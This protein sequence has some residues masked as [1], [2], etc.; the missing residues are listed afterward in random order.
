MRKLISFFFLLAFAGT[1]LAQTGAR[2]EPTGPFAGIVSV[3]SGPIPYL[4]A[5]P[6]V[7]LNWCSYPANSVQ[8]SPCT[9]Y[10]PTF[11]DLTLATPCSST[12]PIVLQ[13]SNIC[14]STGDNFGNL[15]VYYDASVASHTYTI[16]SGSVTY[17]P[18]L[19]SPG[20]T[21][22]GAGACS[23]GTCLGIP[24]LGSP[25][26]V[27]FDGADSITAI[28]GPSDMNRAYGYVAAN[29]ANVVH[30]AG[31]ETVNGSK[32]FGNDMTINAN[33]NLNGTL[34]F[35]Q[36]G[37]LLISGI[38]QTSTP[39]VPAGK[40]YSLYLK[41]GIFNCILANTNP[42][43]GFAPSGI[44]YVNPLGQSWSQTFTSGM[45]LTG[46][47]TGV[48]CAT[49]T[50]TLTSCP[51]GGDTKTGLYQV[52]IADGVNG[53]EAVTITGGTCALA[54]GTSGTMTFV[55]FFSHT[56]Y[57]FG[58]A[59]SGIQEAINTACGISIVLPYYNSQ[60]NV[61][62]PAN[63]PYL[64]G[65]NPGS[66][67][68]LNNYNVYGTIVFHANQSILSGYGVSINCRETL[69]GPCLQIGDRVLSGNYQ[70]N[71]VS[72][73]TFR[74]AVDVSGIAAYAGV[75]VATTA[76]AGSVITETTA[77]A[78]SFRPKDMVVTLFTDDP[79]YWGDEI[80]ST[81][82]SSTTFTTGLGGMQPAGPSQNTPGV[83]AL[84]YCAILDNGNDT[85][86]YDIHYDYTGNA[87]AFNNFF[88]FWDDE[89]AIVDNFNSGG[90]GL[91]RNINWAGAYI[92]SAGAHVSQI[93][94][95]VITVK[96]SDITAGGSNGVTVYNSNSVNIEDTILQ[97][98]ALWQ[99]H[100]SNDLGGFQGVYLQNIYPESGAQVNPLSPAK[101]PFPGLGVGGLIVGSS[102]GA[103]NPRIAGNTGV[104]GSFPSGAISF[105]L[106]SVTSGGVYS[107]V[108]SNTFAANIG[109]GGTVSFSGWSNSANNI[110][111]AVV[112]SFTSSTISVSN[113]AIAACPTLAVTV[114]ENKAA[115]ATGSTPFTY[116][117]VANDTTLGSQTSPMQILNWTSTLGDSI[118]VRWP[119]VANLADTITY[120]VIRMTTPFSTD[121]TKPYPYNSG[122]GTTGCPGGAAGICGYVALGI[123]QATACNVAG[124]PTLV[125]TYTDT[126]SSTTSPY[127]VKQGNYTAAGSGSA[128]GH[129]TFWPGSLVSVNKTVTVDTEAGPVV[130]VGLN[131]NP[132]QAANQC[133]SLGVASPGGYSACTSS[134]MQ[135]N[136][137]PN[138]SATLMGDGS[139]ASGMSMSKG[140]LN[141]PNSASAP[142]DPHHVITI[143]DSQPALTFATPTFRPLASV[144]DCFIGL[145]V[146][147]NTSPSLG[148][149]SFGCPV[150][151]TRYIGQVGNGVTQNWL[152]RLTATKDQ[153]KV[154]IQI[155]VAAFSTLAACAAGTEGMQA[156]ISD[157]TTNTWGA[158]ITG[159]GANHVL[160][161]CNGTNW[162]VS[163]K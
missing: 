17:G 22:G 81:V 131:G 19:Y 106:A 136:S 120:D 163:A 158:T 83:V 152:E 88:D 42:C 132:I 123:T 13:G 21:G 26:L 156:S 162:T 7:K 35:T 154:P 148:Q 71:T 78:H 8:G 80:I 3:S 43:S 58:T 139:V 68:S 20:G 63:G 64:S 92:F 82:P 126:G 133:S 79:A 128:F 113:P 127:T 11:T 134:H 36:A 2:W 12:Q 59:S 118:P 95:P 84:E 32:T 91:N 121:I 96:N 24:P 49:Q 151:L 16:T 99:V 62:I 161:Y 29:D 31:V 23:G 138:Q 85:H 102:T 70:H 34:N 140:R 76:S 14:R 100:V 60:C 109:V 124:I 125:C 72:G 143:S 130:G 115:T 110:Q 47:P 90:N 147:L 116:Y 50:V 119:R 33:L 107:G 137:T 111:N 67:W 28:A 103:A 15:G 6:G 89:G 142:L 87:G 160:G 27:V 153:F 94:A 53:N 55:P 48:S 150:A 61:T 69:R 25:G 149:M 37:P 38:Q 108:V 135:F 65:S 1:C 146:A 57:T 40:D 9:N 159:G 52:Y 129:L 97:A 145:D 86:F 5:L 30:T 112:C 18:Y 101:T 39:M 75:Q 45:N 4:L 44:T 51:V 122:S 98:T 41:G 105:G 144:N 66:N 74:T 141:F 10:S 104:Q 93:I 114:S 157:S 56:S 155:T 117:I 77:V 73:I 46:C 54:G